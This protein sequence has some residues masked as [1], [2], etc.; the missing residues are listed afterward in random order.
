MVARRSNYTSEDGG[1]EGYRR[2]GYHIVRIGDTFKDERYIVQS[3]LG[4][5]HF[6]TVWLSWDI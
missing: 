3:K 5:G 6:S 2:G 1:T 4:W